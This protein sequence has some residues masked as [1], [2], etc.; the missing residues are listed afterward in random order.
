MHYLAF[1]LSEDADGVTSL[2][3]MASTPADRPDQ[4]AAVM[5]EVERVLGWAWTHYPHSHGPIDD[6][7]DWDHDLQVHAE[8]DCWH[9]VNLTIA[10]S[11]RFVEAFGAAFGTTAD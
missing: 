1:D 6:G 9:V 7:M 3:A 10:G 11:P 5:A 8:D 2:E 4:Q